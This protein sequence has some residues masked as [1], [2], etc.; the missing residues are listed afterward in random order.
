VAAAHEARWRHNPCTAPPA[1]QPHEMGALLAAGPT[2]ALD[3]LQGLATSQVSPPRPNQRGH[4]GGSTGGPGKGA[5][6]A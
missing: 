4:G 2:S 6:I 3:A 1:P 5:R